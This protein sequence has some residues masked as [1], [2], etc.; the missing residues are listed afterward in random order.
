MD[1]LS[2]NPVCDPIDVEFLRRE[3][4]RV[5]SVLVMAQQEKE[6]TANAG[7]E[8]G[9]SDGRNWRGVVPHL[10]LILTLTLDMTSLILA[11]LLI[12]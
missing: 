10:R 7:A 11:E 5:R 3:V 2:R 8:S 1:W 12:S 6:E 9:V 4:A